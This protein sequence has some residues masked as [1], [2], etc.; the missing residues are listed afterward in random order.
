[1]AYYASFILQIPIVSFFMSFL[2][3]ELHLFKYVLETNW[4][5]V[6]SSQKCLYI[7]I[8]FCRMLCRKYIFR[9]KDSHLCLS[10]IVI[11]LNLVISCSRYQLFSLLSV[12]E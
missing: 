1:M 10:I 7:I 3:F 2:S 11:G 8:A 4:S 5:T 12:V 6:M 9:K